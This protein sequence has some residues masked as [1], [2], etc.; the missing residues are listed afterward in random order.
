MFSNA[1]FEAE[2]QAAVKEAAPLVRSIAVRKQL[3]DFEAQLDVVTLDDAALVVSY[4]PQCVRLVSATAATASAPAPAPPST[5]AAAAATEWD[6]LHSCLS[7]ISA[8]YRAAH[9]ASL[10]E[11]LSALAAMRDEGESDEE[12]GEEEEA[13]AAEAAAAEVAAA[14][15]ALR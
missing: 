10:M 8:S 13:R 5:A 12:E 11:K 15:T 6:S 4:T 3:R 14:S 9:A 7:S 1:A 2:V